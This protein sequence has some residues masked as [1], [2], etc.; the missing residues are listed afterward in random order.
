MDLLRGVAVMLVL[1]VV[2]A[3][4]AARLGGSRAEPAC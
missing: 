4:Y 1:A 3:S 2:V